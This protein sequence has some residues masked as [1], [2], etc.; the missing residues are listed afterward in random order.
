MF[1]RER[2]QE[3]IE[4][5]GRTPRWLARQLDRSARVTSQYLN[6]KRKVERPLAITIAVAFGVPP[7]ELWVDEGFDHTRAA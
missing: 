6:G 5:Q 4:I 3:L 1:I 7:E 2:A